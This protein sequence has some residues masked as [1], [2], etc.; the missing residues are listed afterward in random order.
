MHS[1]H[2]LFW[3]RKKRNSNDFVSFIFFSF[4]FSLRF[5][6]CFVDFI[7]S[8]KKWRSFDFV[9][10]RIFFLWPVGPL[11]FHFCLHLCAGRN[12]LHESCEHGWK[13]NELDHRFRLDQRVG[14][15]RRSWVYFSIAD[16]SHASPSLT[17]AN[18]TWYYAPLQSTH[19]AK[20]IHRHV[21]A[22]QHFWM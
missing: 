12:G 13:Q 10:E 20:S 11:L 16:K 22:P 15:K 14:D 9:V 1:T 6:L 3:A 8:S 2:K 18:E 4:L 19:S 17:I 7:S 21:D 5:L